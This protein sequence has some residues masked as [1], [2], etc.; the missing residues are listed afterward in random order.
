MPTS[1]VKKLSHKHGVSTSSGESAWKKA[2]KAALKSG[3]GENFAYVTSIFKKEMHEAPEAPTLKNLTE[4][5]TFK[6]FLIAEAEE[7]V[8]SSKDRSPAWK[9]LSKFP[10]FNEL[11]FKAK[12]ELEKEASEIVDDYDSLP[13]EEQESV[14]DHMHDA[15][16]DAMQKEVGVGPHMAKWNEPDHDSAIDK[17]ED[18]MGTDAETGDELPAPAQVA[19][20]RRA[21]SGPRMVRFT[22]SAHTEPADAGDSSEQ[23]PSD[24]SVHSAAA[25]M[26]GMVSKPKSYYK[27]VSALSPEQRAGRSKLWKKHGLVD[28][29]KRAKWF[30][31]LSP[32]IRQEIIGK[33]HN[34]EYTSAEHARTH[35]TGDHSVSAPI[36]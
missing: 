30:Q 32:E 6:Y 10:Q 17:W 33:I 1:Y 7:A 20:R 31:A 26:P 3:H 14:D 29:L 36:A 24:A 22:P 35:A 15:V 12:R 25:T 23:T 5:L 4:G 13:P 27:S 34:E 16:I 28:R 11:S 18:E 2:K 9:Y 19:P 21:S 8:E